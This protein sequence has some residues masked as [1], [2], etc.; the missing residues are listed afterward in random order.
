MADAPPPSHSYSS[1]FSIAMKIGEG[2][3]EALP[4]KFGD[5]V[6][7]QP[8]TLQPQDSPVITPVVLT[9]E[10]KSQ[11]EVSISAGFIDLMNHIAHAKAADKI[12]PGFFQ[13]YIKNLAR[14]NSNPFASPDMVDPRFWTDDVLNDQISYFNQIVSMLM[15][16][17][18]SHHYLGHYNKYV[19]QLANPENKAVPINPLLSPAEWD[20]SV[21][22]GVHNSL[23][24]A[25][26]TEGVRALFEAIDDMPQRPPWT[27]YIVPQYAD[28]KK[29]NKQLDKWE[30]D[31]FHGKFRD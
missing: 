31:F 27:T 19:N 30:Y 15:A 25:L 5:Q 22:A 9:D 18:L 24:C 6:C 12:Q 1:G 21:K 7:A 26:A 23:D 3:Y 11:R 13:A 2:L 4:T 29:L 8:V 20:V 28:L 16:I 17:N 14:V 10:S